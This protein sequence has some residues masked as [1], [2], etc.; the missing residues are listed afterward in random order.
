MRLDF[1]TI[2]RHLQSLE[3]AGF[4]IRIKD[5]EDGRSRRLKLTAAGRT[6]LRSTAARRA[7]FF[8]RATGRW[9]AKDFRLLVGLLSRLARDLKACVGS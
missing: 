1:S 9:P 6:A 5:S 8:R 4:L 2:S 3:S 7:E